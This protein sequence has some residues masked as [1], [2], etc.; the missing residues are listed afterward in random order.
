MTATECR[1]ALFASEFWKK[2]P[3][4]IKAVHCKFPMWAFYED[5]TGAPLR[6]VGYET[7][8]NGVI[9][10]DTVRPHEKNTVAMRR[11]PVQ[12]LMRVEAWTDKHRATAKAALSAKKAKLFL[13]ADGFEAF[14]SPEAPTK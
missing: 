12:Q 13:R 5:D 4:E 3:I 10:A 1:D 11:V 6:I 9:Y 14:K 7:K 2:L 8:Q